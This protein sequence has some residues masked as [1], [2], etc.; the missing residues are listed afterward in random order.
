M[1]TVMTTLIVFFLRFVISVLLVLLVAS[2][3]VLAI[4]GR[5]S[6]KCH[7]GGV[8]VG[9]MALAMVPWSLSH[10]IFGKSE[11]YLVAGPI[12]HLL[13]YFEPTT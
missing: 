11:R 12:T 9:L 8:M 5:F 4:L 7:K 1:K 3:P 2:L 6:S 10:V 13:G